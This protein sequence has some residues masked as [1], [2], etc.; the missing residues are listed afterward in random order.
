MVMFTLLVMLSSGAILLVLERNE[1][2][3]RRLA[4]SP[5]TRTSIILGKWGGRVMIGLIQIGWAM[6]VG[7]LPPFRMD[8]GPHLPMLLL[9]LLVYA[10]VVA[11]LGMILGS[12]ARTPAQSI[13][14][15]I[16]SANVLAALG[17]CWWP[18]EITPEWMQRLALAL[19]TGWAM[20]ALH[21]LV[22][23]GAGPASVLPHL[24]VFLVAGVVAARVSARVFRFQ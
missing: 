8:W 18:I 11:L 21:K 13:G 24:L 2:L 12:L 1:G 22:S 5:L 4:S 9:V 14:L 15:G 19:P 10:G 16:L 6:V 7:T 23:F 17:G 3:L 20:D